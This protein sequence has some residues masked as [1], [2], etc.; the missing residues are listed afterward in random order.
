MV[1]Y[2][3][4]QK[5]L[6]TLIKKGVCRIKWIDNI[7]SKI[8]LRSI[9]KGKLFPYD[10]SSL[11]NERL[12]FF[13]MMELGTLKEHALIKPEKG[14]GGFITQAL[15]CNFCE[16]EIIIPNYDDNSRKL[17]THFKE[18]MK[19]NYKEVQK[20]VKVALDKAYKTLYTKFL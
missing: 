1:K 16:E 11:I 12:Q 9:M 10:M 5:N 2:Q 18:H 17:F 13:V 3:D 19:D 4:W 20:K 14:V 15:K 7:I 8:Q 6:I